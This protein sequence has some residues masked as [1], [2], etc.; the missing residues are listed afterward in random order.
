MESFVL[1]GFVGLGM[2]K[3][4]KKSMLSFKVFKRCIYLVKR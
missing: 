3:K 4:S 1:L 2:S